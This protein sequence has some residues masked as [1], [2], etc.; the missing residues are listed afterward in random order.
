MTTYNLRS[1]SSSNQGSS[2]SANLFNNASTT[3]SANLFNNS[4]SQTPHGSNVFNNQNST[5]NIFNNNS[6][7]GSAGSTTASS[8][9]Y[10]FKYTPSTSTTPAY[11]YGSTPKN[12]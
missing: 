6:A 12:N 2:P 11:T 9:N 5:M 3:S 4:T 7:R 1:Q 10:L 8:N